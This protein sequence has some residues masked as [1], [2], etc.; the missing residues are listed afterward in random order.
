MVWIDAKTSNVGKEDWW[1]DQSNIC[2]NQSL[3]KWID[4]R[5]FWQIVVNIW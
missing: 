1:K 3:F 5:D 4:F 2:D